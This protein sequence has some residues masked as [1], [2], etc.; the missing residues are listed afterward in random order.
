MCELQKEVTERRDI[1]KHNEDPYLRKK[2][3]NV[4]YD[5]C[6]NSL[7]KICT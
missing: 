6:I 4:S 7:K 1:V 2:K 3:E 5:S